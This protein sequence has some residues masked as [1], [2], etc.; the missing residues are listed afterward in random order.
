LCNKFDDTLTYLPLFSFKCC[1]VVLYII[2]L[3]VAREL[4]HFCKIVRRSKV[5]GPRLPR[6][7][8]FSIL[9]LKSINKRKIMATCIGRVRLKLIIYHGQAERYHKNLSDRNH[10]DKDYCIEQRLSQRNEQ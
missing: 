3:E 6:K 1:A 7:K 10:L 4:S 8:S 5:V 9:L 2:L